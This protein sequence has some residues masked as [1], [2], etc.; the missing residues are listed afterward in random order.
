MSA[1]LPRSSTPS[2]TTIRFEEWP[3]IQDGHRREWGLLNLY[4][5]VEHDGDGDSFDIT[6]IEFAPAWESCE[7]HPVPDVLRPIIEAELRGRPDD[8]DHIRQAIED[9]VPPRDAYR[10]H[11]LS[12]SQLGVG[13]RAAA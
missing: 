1:A 12:A 8:R 11:R 2:E 7:R 10:E 3:L 5:T 4:V 6:E 9:V 13:G